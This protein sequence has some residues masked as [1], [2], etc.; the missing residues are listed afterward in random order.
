MIYTLKTTMW[1]ILCFVDAQSGEKLH[2]SGGEPGRGIQWTKESF[3]PL[4][5]GRNREKPLWLVLTDR[6][7]N[8]TKQ[9]WPC[10]FWQLGFLEGINLNTILD[11]YWKLKLAKP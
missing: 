6:K 8:K 1:Y 3:S 2:S 7:Q 4:Q 9:N 11:I 10:W 5:G